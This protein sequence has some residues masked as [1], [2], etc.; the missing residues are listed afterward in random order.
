MVF[1]KTREHHRRGR[2]LVTGLF[3]AHHHVPNYYCHS[4]RR[5]NFNSK[6]DKE[7]FSIRPQ[8][9]LYISTFAPLVATTTINTIGYHWNVN[10]KYTLAIDCMF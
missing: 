7:I 4:L 3:S 5:E 1:Q 9:S 10:I 8:S 6:R 2:G